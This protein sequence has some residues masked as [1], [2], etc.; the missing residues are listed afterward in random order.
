M[1]MANLEPNVFFRKRPRRIRDDVFETLQ[2]ESETQCIVWCIGPH[3][4]ALTVFLLL[5]VD[6][7]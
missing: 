6:Y 3:L 2:G 1:H 7:T 5:L 4:Q